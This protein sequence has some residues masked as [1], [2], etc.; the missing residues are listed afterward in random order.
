MKIEKYMKKNNSYKYIIRSI[1][2][3]KLEIVALLLM[4]FG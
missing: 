2:L 3:Y 4:E 1:F